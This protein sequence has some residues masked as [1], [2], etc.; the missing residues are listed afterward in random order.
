MFKV[1]FFAVPYVGMTFGVA[2]ITM[3][4]LWK[5]SRK[6]NYVTAVDMVKDKW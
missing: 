5:L 1:Y 6:H 3:P 4:R 2:L